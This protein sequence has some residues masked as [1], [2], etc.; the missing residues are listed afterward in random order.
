[1]R[2]PN[3]LSNGHANSKENLSTAPPP[4]VVTDE[5]A[6][7]N[8]KRKDKTPRQHDTKER[9][10]RKHRRDKDNERKR[11][12]SKNRSYEEVGESSKG[13]WDKANDSRAA[14]SNRSYDKEEYC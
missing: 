13:A 1:M 3:G 14:V 7:V 9:S 2:Q 12:R 6:T 8:K 4:Q 11:S 5:Y 10:E